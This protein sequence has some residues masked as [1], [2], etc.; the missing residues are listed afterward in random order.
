MKFKTF[1]W[2][3]VVP[4]LS[5]ASFTTFAA[6]DPVVCL[7]GFSTL[8]TIN[9]QHLLDGEIL[10][11]R[12][13]LMDFPQGICAQNCFAVLRSAAETAKLLQVWNPSQHD[14]L[15]VLAFRPV[16]SPC[17]A[18]DFADLILNPTHHALRWLLDKSRATTGQQSELNLTH[19]EAEELASCTKDHADPQ[20]IGCYWAK[21]LHHRAAAFQ[22]QGFAGVNPYEVTGKTVSS[23]AQIRAMLNEKLPVAREFA[24]L[25]QQCGVLGGEPHTALTPY[26]YW[27]LCDANQRG[28]LNLGAVYLL[29]LGDH[30]Q[31]L[32]A[33]YYVSGNYS[34]TVTLYQVWPIQVGD[35]SG[36]LVWRGDFFAAPTLAYTKG[37]ERLAY[38]TFMQQELKKSIRCFQDDA[39]Q[40]TVVSALPVP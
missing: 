31:L 38:G 24:A 39:N 7:R 16:Q 32:D 34:S 1:L 23:V 17:A 9:L 15:K 6:T 18:S 37:I 3:A 35:K 11:D 27:G 2:F 26:Q 22:S 33:E 12:G 36:A 4:L 10:G 29:P 20:A 19:V 13:S 30:Y 8:P 14:S 21:L 28:T 40:P 25:L 5:F